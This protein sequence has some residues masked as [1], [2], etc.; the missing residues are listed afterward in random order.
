MTATMPATVSEPLPASRDPSLRR[1]YRPLGPCRLD[2][3]DPDRPRVRADPGRPV[4]HRPVAPP[5]GIRHGTKPARARPA[6]RRP[7]HR[8]SGSAPPPRGWPHLRLPSIGDCLPY[9]TD[10]ARRTTAPPAHPNPERRPTGRQDAREAGNGFRSGSRTPNAAPRDAR[11]PAKAPAEPATKRM[12]KAG[13]VSP[14]YRPAP[15]GTDPPRPHRATARPLAAT[16][17]RSSEPQ[18]PG[19]SGTAE[20]SPARVAQQSSD[21]PVAPHPRSCLRNGFFAPRQ[22]PAPVGRPTSPGAELGLRVSIAH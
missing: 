10:P 17:P 11:A 2:R 6:G 3:D 19:V 14:R 18:A 22:S 13:A 1:R 21:L 7:T 4:A 20:P 12:G 15:P 16:D 5:V 9:G 8:R